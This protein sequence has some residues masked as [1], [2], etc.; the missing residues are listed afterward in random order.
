[1][2]YR[3]AII[4]Y[5]VPSCLNLRDYISGYN[6][7]EL[8]DIVHTHDDGL[9]V[10]LK[11]LPD[12]VFINLTNKDAPS[13]FNMVIQL[14]QFIQKTPLFIAY[15]ESKEYAYDALK[16]GFFDYWLLPYSHFDV[17]KTI[18]KLRKQHPKEK[19]LSTICLKTYRD[20]HYL[21]TSEI[22]YL[23]ADNNATDFILTDGDKV[24]AYKTLKSFEKT[25]PK[26]FIR[27]HQSYILNSEYIS[28]I[29]YGKSTCTLKN[30]SIKIPFS[31]SYKTRIDKLQVLLSNNAIQHIN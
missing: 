21:D 26:S 20:F 14:H 8:A 30:N 1:M 23:Q 2:S 12:I 31:K 9:N 25:L 7:F 10:I 27:I 6:D 17:R 4:D 22:L 3:Y 28:R 29:N 19:E 11:Y 15:S 18:F 24:S 16:N 13:Y 5:N